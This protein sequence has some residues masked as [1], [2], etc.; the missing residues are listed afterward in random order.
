L[1]NPCQRVQF[2][3]SLIFAFTGMSIPCFAPFFLPLSI[4]QHFC[5]KPKRGYEEITPSLPATTMYSGY[6]HHFLPPKKYPASCRV[7]NQ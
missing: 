3:S 1:D 4:F 7:M 5:F 2:H 6:R